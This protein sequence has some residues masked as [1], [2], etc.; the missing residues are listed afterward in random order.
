MEPDSNRNPRSAPVGRTHRFR[1]ET[2]SSKLRVYI[3]AN[4]MKLTGVLHSSERII[5]NKFSMM[6]GGKRMLYS[7][8]FERRISLCTR[9][10]DHI[11]AAE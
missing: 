2:S 7:P 4:G 5:K 3:Q 9:Q 1:L 8:R 11:I 6:D 10:M